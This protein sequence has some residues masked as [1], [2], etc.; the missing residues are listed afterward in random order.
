MESPIGRPSLDVGFLEGVGSHERGPYLAGDRNNGNAIHH[1]VSDSSYQIRG[2]GAGGRNTH[3]DLAASARESARSKRSRG[4]V[5]NEYVAHRMA[6][7][8]VV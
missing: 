6:E 7:E 5:A 8:S 1:G 4:F 2:A 3:T